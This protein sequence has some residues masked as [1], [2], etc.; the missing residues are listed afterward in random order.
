[1]TPVK[2]MF[3]E[4]NAQVAFEASKGSVTGLQEFPEL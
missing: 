3:T 2:A 1:M 4:S